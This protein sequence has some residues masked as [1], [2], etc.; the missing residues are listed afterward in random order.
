MG[1]CNQAVTE[2]AAVLMD[3]YGNII[4]RVAYSYL[5]NMEDAEDI[6][7]DTLIQFLRN[8]PTFANDSHEKA[9]LI[10][11]A[12]N[13]S[14]NKILYLKRRQSDELSEE[15][16]ADK[17]KEDLSYVWEAV[18]ALPDKYRE[19]VHLFYQEGYSTKEIAEI[20]SRNES[21]VRSDLKRGRDKLKKIL[22]EAY[23]FG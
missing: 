7:Q 13:L 19:V 9:W 4:L 18:K 20:L 12:S 11:V 3:K 17:D 14:K 2:R 5:H 6:L 15:L 21:T 16:V 23:D 22:K 10:T 8:N 1:D